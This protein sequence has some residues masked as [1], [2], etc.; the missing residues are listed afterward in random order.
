MHL[1]SIS[2][3]HVDLEQLSVFIKSWMN[4]PKQGL[5]V[6]SAS[7][8]SKKATKGSHLEIKDAEYEKV[9]ARIEKKWNFREGK[10]ENY[11]L[12]DRN[13]YWGNELIVIFDDTSLHVAVDAVRVR[14]LKS[15]TFMVRSSFPIL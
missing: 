14:G 1:K 12:A 10:A 2:E 9:R 3:L 7:I 6:N 13:P 5:A 8:V 4:D 15:V 11:G